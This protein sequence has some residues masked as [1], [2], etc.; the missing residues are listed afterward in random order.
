MGNCA[1]CHFPVVVVTEPRGSGQRP[2]FFPP[3][4][5]RSPSFT[6]FHFRQ[7]QPQHSRLYSIV[8]IVCSTP[9]NLSLEHML[10]NG[11]SLWGASRPSLLHQIRCLSFLGSYL[12]SRSHR[13]WSPGNCV[14]CCRRTGKIGEDSSTGLQ[15]PGQRRLT[16]MGSAASPPG[17]GL[18]E[19]PSGVGQGEVLHWFWVQIPPLPL[20]NCGF[21]HKSRPFS[22]SWSACYKI[23]KPPASQTK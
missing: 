10:T 13:N 17:Q 6:I 22:G 1:L 21:V 14:V 12:G 20:P 15:G 16:L 19:T 9:G 3:Q 7:S 2:P 23:K 18:L 8:S 5:P 11:Q 4:H